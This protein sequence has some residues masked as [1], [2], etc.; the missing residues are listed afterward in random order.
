MIA[1]ASMKLTMLLQCIHHYWAGSSA[2]L[3]AKQ[4]HYRLS[5]QHLRQVVQE[6]NSQHTVAQVHAL[7]P[8]VTGAF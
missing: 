1:G 4:Q 7:Q 5:L 2:D 8:I 6:W 3:H